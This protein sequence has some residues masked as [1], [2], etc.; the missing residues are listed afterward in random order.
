MEQTKVDEK[1]IQ[2][3]ITQQIIPKDPV[4]PKFLECSYRKQNYLNKDGKIQF[5][6]IIRFLS[7]YYK[8]DDLKVL[9][10]CGELKQTDSGSENAINALNCI[11][12]KLLPLTEIYDEEK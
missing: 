1:S 7:R 11:L 2:M 9:N 8:K 10:V 6:N 5:Q 3:V 4:Y 12:P